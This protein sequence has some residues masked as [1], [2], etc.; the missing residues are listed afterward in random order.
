M[1]F[2]QKF[3]IKFLTS[4]HKKNKAKQSIC[5]IKRDIKILNQNFEKN[6]QKTP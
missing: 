2:P 5:E 4:T 6:L 3:S 1:N